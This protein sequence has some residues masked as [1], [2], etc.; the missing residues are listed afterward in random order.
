MA[1]DKKMKS[2]IKDAEEN[3]TDV[4]KAGWG[5]RL[6]SLGQCAACETPVLCCGLKIVTVV[7]MLKKYNVSFETGL[8]VWTPRSRKKW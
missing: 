4:L 8:E 3:P 6:D 5:E 1:A 2:V 7:W